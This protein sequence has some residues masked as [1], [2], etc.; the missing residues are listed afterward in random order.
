MKDFK[1]E[2]V[3]LLANILVFSVLFTV[4]SYSFA[5]NFK[6][7][8]REHFETHKISAPGVD[9]TYKGLS[10]TLNFWWENPY[11]IY[12]GF[13]VSPV[14]ASLKSQDSTNPMGEKVDFI[15][16]GFELK[17]F[18]KDILSQVF[19]R[20]GVTYSHLKPKNHISSKSGYA[21][22]LGIGY[23]YPFDMFGLAVEYGYRYAELSD[24]YK[25][26]SVTPSIGFHFYKDL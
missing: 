15:N 9:T 13:S 24:D 23:E 12:Y 4:G 11:D 2:K 26:E 18:F 1:G 22:Y 14:L 10:N 3:R 7:R 25:V 20:P 21:L 16:V 8:A 5:M 19:V 17:Y 6:V